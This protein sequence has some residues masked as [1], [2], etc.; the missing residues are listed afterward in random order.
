MP[1]VGVKRDL[2]FKALGKT[3][4]D[5][6]FQ[7]FCFEFG[8][9]LDEV[10][11]EKQMITKEQGLVEAAKDASEEIIYRIDIPANR[12]DLLCLEGLVMGLQVFMGKIKFP[13]FTK[14]GPVGKGVAPQKLIVTKATAQIRP[15]A[16][17][18]VLR[19]ITFTKDSYD[20]FIDLQDKL[21]QNICRKRTLVAIGTH[22]LDKLQGPF[23]FDAKPPKDIRF[24][25]LNQEKAMTGDELMEFYSTHA[26]L[27]TYL[28]IIRDS[29]VYPV[30]YDANGVVLSLPPII[31]GDHSK[32]TLQ[33]KNVFI[34]CTATDLT[35]ARIVLDTLVC[36]FS[37]H[38]A[39]Q[40][41][42]EY[43]EVVSAS[44]ETKQYPDLAFR[45]ETI[46]VAETNAYI[47][48]NESAEKMAYLLNRLL[49]TKQTA[50][51]T[52][53]VEVP[54]TRHDILHACDIYEDVAIG[55]GYNRIPK[56]L[57]A[58]M[59]IA[60]Q[61]PLNKLTEQLREQIAQ[62]G[63][64]EGLTFTLCSRDD[65]A[66]KMNA[67]IDQIPA[68]HIANPKT[69]E[70]QVV[71]TT[72]I[73]G[74]L[75]TLAANRKMPLPLKLFEVSDVVLADSKSEVGAKNERRVCAINCN[76]TAGFEV[77]HGLL[78]RVMQLLEV[79][80]DRQTGYYLQACDDPAYFPGRC[81]SVLYKGAAI[82]RIGVLHPTVLQAF[83]LTTPCSV[84]EFNME[85]FV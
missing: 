20:S 16:V 77:V 70:F 33:T 67:Q 73:P 25:P 41:T 19:D 35:K 11:T 32:I 71:R 75:K 26:Q 39:K 3:Y 43:C 49:P 17:A 63:F 10:T 29:P 62:A 13:R 54:P 34:E 30:I 5:D 59:H 28:P 53:E 24:V 78:D 40:F 38:C 60:K 14:V 31:N 8:L 85:Y 45:K 81:A 2:L 65:I 21:H 52:L 7:K 47:G 23:T 66:T 22:D 61:Y 55:Y 9:E 37:T 83:E 18:A 79:P 56:T 15:F 82:G 69:L 74:L 1:T 36:M 68:V 84:V 12:Y 58:K 64:T 44:G 76:K 48:L 50:P 4:T 42:V 27:K 72:L 6:E 46:S 57:P 80:W 51:D